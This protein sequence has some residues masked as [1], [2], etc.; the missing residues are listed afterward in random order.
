MG[1]VIVMGKYKNHIKFHKNGVD[2]VIF[3]ANVDEIISN[4]SPI[5]FDII[6]RCGINIWRDRISYQIIAQN[7]TMKKNEHSFGF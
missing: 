7:Y 5:S 2:F 6:G 4:D 1:S 3:N